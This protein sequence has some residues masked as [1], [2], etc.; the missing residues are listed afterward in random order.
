MGIKSW[1]E[2]GFAISIQANKI[3]SN[4]TSLADE[5]DEASSFSEI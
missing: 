2:N 5:E 4:M 1:D 3:S